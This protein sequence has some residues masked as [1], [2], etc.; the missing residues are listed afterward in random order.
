MLKDK[1]VIITGAAGGI[2]SA[3]AHLFAKHGAIL[4]LTD[5]HKEGLEDLGAFLKDSGAET[6]LVEHDVADPESWQS[7]ME[8]VRQKYGKVDILINNAGVVQPGA[9]EKITLDEVQ[10][11]LSVN[12]S[13]TIHGCRAALGI[14]KPQNFGKIVNVASLGGVVPLPGEAVYSATK[15]AIRGYSLSLHAELRRTPVGVTVVCPDS[16]DTAQHDYELLFDS[17]VLSFLGKPLK[18]EQ[19]AKGILKAVRKKKPEVMIPTSMGILCRIGVAFPKIFFFLLPIME[20]M[21]RSTIKK[22]REA[23]KEPSK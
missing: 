9:A 5:I 23:K 7:L 11:Q 21:G 2:G 19:A 4:I 18:P 17:A 1:V 14:M 13:G 20:K 8:K 6:M 16:V 22:R 10:S 12:L 15:Y 3:T